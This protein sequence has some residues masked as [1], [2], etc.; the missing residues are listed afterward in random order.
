[1][2]MLSLG[3][4]RATWII[5]SNLHILRLGGVPEPRDMQTF[6]PKL[7]QEEA[8]EKAIDFVWNDE[9]LDSNTYIKQVERVGFRANRADVPEDSKILDQDAEIELCALKADLWL[10]AASELAAGME[11]QR[12]GVRESFDTSGLSAHGIVP[13]RPD[14]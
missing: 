3:D 2:G 10:E 13:S 7:W 6:A 5:Y 14:F 4:E 1:M 8:R 9:G 12:R 11:R